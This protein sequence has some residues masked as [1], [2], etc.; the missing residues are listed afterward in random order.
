MRNGENVA[1]DW[2][3]GGVLIWS[4]VYSRNNRSMAPNNDVVGE[5]EKKKHFISSTVTSAC[6]CLL[7][8]LMQPPLL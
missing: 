1:V 7:K 6:L 2:L 3:T 8:A 5:W 4:L